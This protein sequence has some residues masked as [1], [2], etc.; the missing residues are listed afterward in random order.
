MAD[1]H[2]TA[3][4][5]DG[6]DLADDVV[7]G[8]YCHVGPRVCI[9]SGGRLLSHVVVTGNTTIGSGVT[10]YPF[11]SV[12]HQPQDLKYKGEDSALTIGHDVTIREHVTINPATQAGRMI[13][14][15]G[16]HCLLMVGS[17]V[18]HDCVLGNH[19]ILV[20]NA[21]L[22]GH[23]EIGDYAII[24]GLSAVHQYVRIGRHVMIGGMSGVEN[25]IIPYGSAVGNRA[26]LSGLNLVGLKRRGF[27]RDTIHA[28]RTA[29][30]LLFAQEG[31]FSERVEDVS[32][33]YTDVEPVMEIIAFIRGDSQRAL[34]Q[35][36]VESTS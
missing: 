25:D 35:P 16:D 13:T 3:I 18:A 5:E 10:I 23:V 15:I 20:N 11:A 17:H 28:L 21:T 1:I 12:G 19:V 33:S 31:S 30:R 24:G 9:G 27:S 4:I 34:C 7:V 26:F 6:A 36:A 2:S 29:Y 32:C 14:E 22:A 8:P